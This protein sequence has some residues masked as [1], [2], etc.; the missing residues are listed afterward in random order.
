MKEQREA[1]INSL[2][3]HYLAMRDSGET[4][5]KSLHLMTKKFHYRLISSKKVSL[6]LH[7]VHTAI[8]TF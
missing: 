8:I 6:L 2:N 3:E 1:I 7:L 4:H 5:A